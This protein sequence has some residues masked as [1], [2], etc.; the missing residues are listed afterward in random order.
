M[1]IVDDHVHLFLEFRPSYSL[2][3]VVQFLK[4][5][6]SYRMFKLHPELKKRYWGGSLWSSGKFFRSVGNVTADTIQ[7]YIKESQGKPKAESKVCRSRES[8][9]R[10]LDDFWSPANRACARPEAYPIPLGWG[11]RAQFDFEAI[12]LGWSNTSDLFCL[13]IFGYI[14]PM[15]GLQLSVKLDRYCIGSKTC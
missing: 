6:S 9:Q 13:D 8:G 3:R 5:G 15:Y 4:G 2:S 7:H 14:N 10:R 11:G 1:E 12:A